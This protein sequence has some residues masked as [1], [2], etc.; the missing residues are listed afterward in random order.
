[1]ED[2]RLDDTLAVVS[3]FGLGRQWWGIG[4]P[5]KG[6]RGRGSP[7]RRVQDNR[8]TGTADGGPAIFWLATGSML[9]EVAW[10]CLRFVRI[11]LE[12]FSQCVTIS[13]T[14]TRLDAKV[15][16]DRW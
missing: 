11:P 2:S 7:E 15:I 10:T 9:G 8:R 13:G 5:G 12:R 3:V 14:G 1:V 6:E 16:F 4:S